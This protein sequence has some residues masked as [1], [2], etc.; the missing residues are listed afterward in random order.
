M[1]EF[2]VKARDWDKNQRCIDRSVAVAKLLLQ[3]VSVKPG[4]KALEYGAGTALLSFELKDH[5]AEIILMDN[6]REMNQV[7]KEKIDSQ[8]VRNMK[9]LFYDLEHEDYDGKFDIIYTQMVMHHVND[10]DTMLSKFHALLNPGG[11]IAI[12]DLYSED[13]TFHSA[14]F[15]GHPGF[16]VDVL[17]DQLK[18]AG[19]SDIK[20]QQVFV[21]PKTNEQGITKEFPVFFISGVRS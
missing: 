14:G 2:D 9:S 11:Y 12:A 1:S 6:S 20:H 5:F 21:I 18:T 15:S 16:N 13:G 10:V 17:G 3:S 19:F 7:A 8:Q 4:M